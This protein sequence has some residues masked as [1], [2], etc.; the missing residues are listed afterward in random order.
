MLS[1]KNCGAQMSGI[2]LVCKKCGTPWG[3]KHKSRKKLYFSIFAILLVACVAYVYFTPDVD[4]APILEIYNKYFASKDTNEEEKNKE[5]IQESVSPSPDTTPEV[6]PSP[7]INESLVVSP[8]PEVTPPVP[9]LPP[10]FSSVTSSS[11][12]ASQGKFSY[13]PNLTIDG[14]LET[15]WLEGA[16]GNGIGEWI[17]Y[18]SENNQTV[19]AI[20]IFNGYLKNN[21]TYLNNGRMKKFSLE[22]SDGTI[23][24]YDIAKLTFNESKKGFE[25]NFDTP[26]VTTSIKLTVLDVYNG[27]YYSDL[28]ISEINFK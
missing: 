9:P 25:I 20:T 26:I 18:S 22:F 21:T 11:S 8:S 13:K 28:A 16:K 4:K 1:C 10:T 17:L 3:K 24:T 6:T 2:D 23:L 19:S 15:A 5:I 7:E 27:A 14:K 12:L